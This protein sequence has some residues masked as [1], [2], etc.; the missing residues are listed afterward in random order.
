MQLD[1]LILDNFYNDPLK[2]RE[3]ALSQAFDVPGNYPG[4]RTVPFF[5]QDVKDLIEQFIYLSMNLPITMMWRL[6]KKP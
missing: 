4:K 3:F 6:G 2:I 5:T 1:L